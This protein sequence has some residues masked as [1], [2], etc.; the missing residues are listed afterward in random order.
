[1]YKDKDAQREYNRERMRKARVAQT[2]NT[3]HDRE[4]GNT[5]YPAL[6]LALADPVKRGKIQKITDSLKHHSMLDNVRY[7]IWGPTFTRIDKLLNT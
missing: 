7:G 3:D 1:M 4:R 5:K 6:V 2:G